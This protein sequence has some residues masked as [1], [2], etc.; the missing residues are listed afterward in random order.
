MDKSVDHQLA[1]VHADSDELSV[2]SHLLD[3]S[4][5]IDT[6][7]ARILAEFASR[8]GIPPQVYVQVARRCNLRCTMCGFAAWQSNQGFMSDAVF[9]STLDQCDRDGV[10]KLIFA[11]A[12][13][14][15]FLH[16]RIFE[17]LEE[18]V[19]RGFQVQASTNGTPFTEERIARLATIPFYHLQFSFAG[20]DQRS[21]ETIY[22]GARFEQVSRNLAAIHRHLTETGS[23]T[24]FSVHGVYADSVM[25]LYSREEF[26]SRTKAYVASLGVPEDKVNIAVPH[27]FGGVVEAGEYRSSA[28]LHSHKMLKSSRP[29]LCPVLMSSPGVYIDGRATACGCLD[30]NGELELGDATTTTLGALRRSEKFQALVKAFLDGDISHLPLCAKCDVPY[31]WGAAR[32]D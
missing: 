3:A 1:S 11:S 9:R 20:F 6:Q 15:P 5:D 22:A 17:L 14:E 24:L 29:A 26:V 30:S 31:E 32:Y 27:N 8:N 28:A 25:G 23:P 18:A 16:P 13:G 19:S 4:L 12:Q 21:Y 10:R 7:N 2:Q